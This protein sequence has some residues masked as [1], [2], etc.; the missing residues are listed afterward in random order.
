MASPPAQILSNKTSKTVDH[1]NAS[2]SKKDGNQKKFF[3]S[4]NEN[5]HELNFSPLSGKKPRL[6]AK[7]CFLFSA[8]IEIELQIGG[9]GVS[10]LSEEAQSQIE[11]GKERKP[12]NR[13]LL[14]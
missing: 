7:K 1:G 4:S 3:F 2:F 10:A 8:S 11:I 9:G 13:R 12:I 6:F 5:F 14:L